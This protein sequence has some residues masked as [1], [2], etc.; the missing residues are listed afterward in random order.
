VKI[1]L[2]WLNEFID[3]SEISVDKLAYELTM[4]GLEVESV[5]DY[6]LVY[7]KFIVAEVLEKIKHPNADKLSVCKVNTGA[8]TLQIVCGAP[9]VAAGQKVPLAIEGAKIP[10]ADFIIKSTKLRGQLSQGMI[11]SEAELG[12]S[13]DHTGI[14]VLPEDSAPGTP[15]AKAIG[16]DDVVFEI[17]ITPNRPDA[18]SHIGVARDLAALFNKPLKKKP[19]TATR[20]VERIWDVANVLVEDEINCPRYSAVVI[21]NCKVGESPVWMKNRLKMAGMRPIN[22]IVDIT[23]YIM[24]ELGQPLHAFDLDNLSGRK[25]IVKKAVDNTKF[26]TLDS[27]ERTLKE[28][29]LMIC[30]GEKEVAVAGIMGGENSEVSENTTNILLESAYFHPTSVRK[31]AKY[32]GLSTEASYR[33]ERGTNHEGTLYAA[34]RAAELMSRF[35]GGKI[36]SGEIDII[37]ERLKPLK[38]ELRFAQIERILGYHVPDAKVVQI[39]KNLDLEVV[40]V[41]ET[42]VAVKVP[43][44]RP[45]IDREIDLIEEVARIHGYDNIPTVHRVT[46]PLE[47]TVDDLELLDTIRG[48]LSGFGF[49]EI[50]NNSLQPNEIAAETGNPVPVLNP[51]NAE[52]A[53]LRSSLIPGALYT[54]RNNLNVG[55]KDLMLFETGHTFN[56]KRDVINSFDDFVED[57]MVTF[58]L[59][60]RASQKTWNSNER[61]FDFYDLKGYFK[62]LLE[63]FMN[64][65]PL[66]HVYNNEEK[67]IFEYSIEVFAGEEKLGVLGKVSDQFCSKFDI[68]QVVYC[69]ELFVNCIKR[70]TDK[71]KKYS[72]LLKYPKIVRDFAFIFDSNIKY[73]EIS[74]FIRKNSSS[75]LKKVDLFDQYEN[76]S[77]IGPGKRSLAFTLEFFENDRTLTEE[78][79]EKEFSGLINKITKHF[80]AVLRGN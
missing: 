64:T 14:M 5:T 57:R 45:D 77:V 46:S 44:F 65:S 19:V 73:G 36:L 6:N 7:D 49:N 13:N 34:N 26:K 61:F 60:G 52:M 35:A 33:F 12:L 21:K 75:L 22:N 43:G 42:K 74:E 23:N 17:G 18:L 25:I 24:L 10:D 56:K 20:D 63:S 8:E 47:S 28:S 51:L 59:T 31:S 72:P 2:S 68:G 70:N 55:E 9:N 4:A 80:N 30:D 76:E 54:V 1:V 27:V 32:L 62:S 66:T 15:L 67:G 71:V 78:E 11:C 38:V 37:S 58:L 53:V 29:V 16:Y 48:I 3:L 79:V 50:M 41:D 40:S 69:A 39:L